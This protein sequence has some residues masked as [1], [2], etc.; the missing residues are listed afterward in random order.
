MCLKTLTRQARRTRTSRVTLEVETRGGKR[1]VVW[2]CD[3][4]V[5]AT[6]VTASSLADDPERFS[7]TYAVE[8]VLAFVR[9]IPKDVRVVP[10]ALGADGSVTTVGP[11]DS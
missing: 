11:V 1:V 7:G 10:L 3:R 4:R 8:D 2:S 9:G 6:A 5:V